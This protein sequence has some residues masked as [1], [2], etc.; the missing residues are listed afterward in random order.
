MAIY[1]PINIPPLREADVPRKY[2]MPAKPETG[3][4]SAIKRLEK[5]ISPEDI[6]RK[7]FPNVGEQEA[8]RI[9]R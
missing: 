8:Q 9:R 7:R 2:K 3:L 5:A 4:Q 6:R 1:S